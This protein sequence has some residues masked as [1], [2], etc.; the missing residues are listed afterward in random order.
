MFKQLTGHLFISIVQL[1]SVF[2]IATSQPNFAFTIVEYQ[3][4]L[5]KIYGKSLLKS[6]DILAI[7]LGNIFYIFK[8]F[9]FLRN[10]IKALLT[11]T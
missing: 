10:L 4:I 3:R 5:L 2:S 6:V 8:Y 7:S 9:Q 11:S 1:N